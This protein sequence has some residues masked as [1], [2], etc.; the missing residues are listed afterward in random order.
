MKTL[1]R[2]GKLFASEQKL[3]GWQ[4]ATAAEATAVGR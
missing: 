4:R 2:C 3:V 1:T